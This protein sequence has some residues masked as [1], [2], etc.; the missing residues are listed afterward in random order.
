MQRPILLVLLAD[1]WWGISALY[2]RELDSIDPVDQL[3]WRILLGVA[4]LGGWWASRRRWPFRGMTRRKWVYGL[5]G[6]V[7]I[8]MNWAVFLWAV[9]NDQAVGAAL[10]Y[11]LSPVL[12][13]VIAVVALGERLDR[14]QQAAVALAAGGLV[15]LVVLQGGVPAVALAL[16]VSFAIYGYVRKT[17]PWDAVDGLTMEMAAVAPFAAVFLLIRGIDTSVSVGGDDRA[18][19]WLLLSFA[20][21][22]TAMPLIL[23]ANAARKA[24]LAVVGLLQYVVPVAQFLVGWLVFAESVPATRFVGF[25]L[26]WAALACVIVNELQQQRR[27]RATNRSAPAQL[28]REGHSYD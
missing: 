22:A 28:P 19:T 13:V 9:S 11:F 26:V 12:S 18:I 1:L 20:G 4:V 25:G 24:P 8:T 6:T 5:L 17:G 27:I 21:L 23:F 16:G 3:A 10:G 15:W 2:W 7:C 14:L